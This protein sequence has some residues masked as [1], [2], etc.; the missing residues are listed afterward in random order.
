[1]DFTR[2]DVLTATG[3]L[4]TSGI[5]TAR[6]S[7]RADGYYGLIGKMT[8]VPGRRDELAAILLE[9]VSTMPGC[10]SY[11]VAA[12]PAS[13]D[14]LWITEVWDNAASHEAS[15]RL[16]AVRAAIA[17]GRPLIAAFGDST[18]TAPIGGHGLVTTGAGAQA[19]PNPPP[20]IVSG[21]VTYRERMALPANATLDVWIVDTTPGQNTAALLAET[22]TPVH[23]QVPLPFELRIEPGRVQH[24]KTYGLQ[25]AIRSGGQTLFA[26]DTPVP[27]IT[28]G[29]PSLVALTLTRAK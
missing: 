26:S 14:T 18:V 15:L 2:R 11:V 23:G 9:G 20:A 28:H 21:T 25:A 4:M 19:T 29:H 16:P 5:A 6:A 12:D 27:V 13:P 22:S 10:L 1:M 3:L 8:A 24:E 17:K 7:G